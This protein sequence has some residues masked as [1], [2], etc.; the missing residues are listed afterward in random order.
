MRKIFHSF[1]HIAKIEFSRLMESRHAKLEYLQGV[2]KL[3]P[4][5]CMSFMSQNYCLLFSSPDE[6]YSKWYF[7]YPS[8]LTSQPLPFLTRHS[9]LVPH[10]DHAPSTTRGDHRVIQERHKEGGDH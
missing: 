10:P 3:L 1:I 5:F 7:C 8:G 9:S 4:T 2:P 6:T